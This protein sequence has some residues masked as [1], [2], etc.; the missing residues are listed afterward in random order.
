MAPFLL[1]HLRALQRHPWLRYANL[2][3]MGERN[4][5]GSVGTILGY[6]QQCRDI[7]RFFPLKQDAKKDWGFF[8]DSVN[9]PLMAEAGR[10][11]LEEGAVCFLQDMVVSNRAKREKHSFWSDDQH[12]DDMKSM[13]YDQLRRLRYHLTVPNTP[14]GQTH[15]GVSGKLDDEGRP[16]SGYDDDVAIA[17]CMNLYVWVLFNRRRLPGLNYELLKPQH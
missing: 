7:E 10:N 16:R 3:F 1:D 11:K 12:R 2:L 13:L 15:L 5:G 9:K 17:F 14:Y 8:T 6:V 4:S